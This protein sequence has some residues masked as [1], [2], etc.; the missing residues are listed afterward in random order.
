MRT[1]LFCLLFSTSAL[2]LEI[3]FIGPCSKESFL[4]KTANSTHSR[5][6]GEL[7]LEV[8][9]A[10][11]IP[12]LGSSRGLNQIGTSP[13][14]DEALVIL[15]DSE[16]LAYG[17]CFEVDGIVP[18]KFPDQVDVRG[19]KKIVWYYAYAHYLRGEWVAQCRPSYLRPP[20]LY[21]KSL[22]R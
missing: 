5:N 2:A 21:C 6:V 14:G 11:K 17:W 13:V 9:E 18:E 10:A 15:S 20:E 7:S 4:R 1:L 19:V 3:E 22:M 12:Y 16:M 8:L